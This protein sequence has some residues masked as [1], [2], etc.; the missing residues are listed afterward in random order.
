MT[1]RP[2]PSVQSSAVRLHLERALAESTD[3]E[4]VVLPVRELGVEFDG[5]PAAVVGAG[6]AGRSAVVGLRE[7]GAEVLLVNRSEERGRKAADDLDVPFEPLAGFDPSPYRIVV[8]ATSLGREAEDPLPFEPLRLAED[9]VVVDLVYT[10]TETPLL[11]AVREA[12]RRAVDGREVLLFQALEQFRMMTGHELPVDLA[13][14]ALGIP[15][16]TPA[17]EESR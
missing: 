15:T 11:A 17:E 12:G 10:D 5:V 6:G 13:H 2:A 3:P 9:A 7:A 4:G 16:S 14:R 1:S 8:H